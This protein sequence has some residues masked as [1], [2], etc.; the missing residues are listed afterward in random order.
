MRDILTDTSKEALVA[1]IEA[2]LFEYRKAFFGTWPKIEMHHDENML[3]SISE[4]PSPHLNGVMWANLAPE[5]VDAAIKAVIARYSARNLPIGWY[6]VSLSSPANLGEHLQAHGFVFEGGWPGMA[7]DLSLLNGDLNPPPGL[8]IK[9][10]LD[11]ET[12]KTCQNI[13][14]TSFG[15]PDHAKERWMDQ[16][17][18]VGF[19]NQ[20][21]IYYYVALLDGEPLATS[22]LVPGAGVAGIYNVATIEDARRQGIGTAV[23]LAAMLEGRNM[24]YRIAVLEATEPGF[25]V[26]KRMGFEKYCDIGTYMYKKED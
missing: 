4:I 20:S 2:N 14:A 15:I 3:W 9:R 18:R 6:D 25:P 12:L 10:V 16:V 23:T 19:S 8:V 11:T 5:K 22:A 13:F 24:G 21:L 1:A 7:M 17:M 26:Y